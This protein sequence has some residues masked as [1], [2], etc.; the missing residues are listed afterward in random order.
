MILNTEAGV[1]LN[2]PVKSLIYHPFGGEEFQ[3]NF[4]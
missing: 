2:Y 4:I 1:L 3:V